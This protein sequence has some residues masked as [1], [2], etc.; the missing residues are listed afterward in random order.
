MTRRT[1]ILLVVF[2]LL[3][4]GS[5]L[6]LRWVMSA[7]PSIRDSVVPPLNARFDSKVE[8]AELQTDFFPRPGI[9]GRGLVLRHDGRTDVPPLI[10]VEHFT[11]S[12]GI[13]G[14][15]GR[16]VRL[17]DVTVE[18]LNVHIPPGG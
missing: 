13:R 8:L 1:R 18:G 4:V 14:L 3:L 6:L 10:T 17:R 11:A 5:G 9:D 7:T 12:A 16:P 2:G 15:F